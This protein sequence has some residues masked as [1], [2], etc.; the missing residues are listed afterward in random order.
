MPKNQSILNFIKI[1]KPNS[2]IE[3]IKEPKIWVPKYLKIP[4][5]SGE[6][7]EFYP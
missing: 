6:T 1:E 5:S 3:K 4:N 7:P 2:E